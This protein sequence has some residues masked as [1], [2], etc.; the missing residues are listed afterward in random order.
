MDSD[1]PSPQLCDAG[2]CVAPA[3]T[4]VNFIA[5]V[6]GNQQQLTVDTPSESL[7]VLGTDSA[8]NAVP[9]ASVTFS[10][11]QNNGHLALDAVQVTDAQGHAENV[12]ILGT[13]AGSNEVTASLDAGPSVAFSAMGAAGP[14]ERLV[15]VSGNSQT[16][17]V[18]TALL[19][20]LVAAV[21]DI[22][23]NLTPLTIAV[24][25]TVTAGNGSLLSMD[26]ETN[27][28]GRAQ[29]ELK[30]GQTSGTNTVKVEA[31][32]LM[33][34]QFTATGTA[35]DAA[36]L[37]IEGGD[38]QTAPGN[39]QLPLPFQV[40]VADA[41]DNPKSG[42][43]VTFSASASDGSFSGASTQTTNADGVAQN[44]F[45]ITRLSGA[46][47]ATVSSSGLT[48]VDFSATAT[49]VN[50]VQNP[51]ITSGSSGWL[52]EGPMSWTDE[53]ES[54]NGMFKSEAMYYPSSWAY[55]CLSVTPGLPYSLSVDILQ[56]AGQAC[57]GLNQR[58]EV[59][60][61]WY[62]NGYP[63]CGGPMGYAQFI[64]LDGNNSWV[65]LT[66]SGSVPAD[67]YG[68]F[69]SLISRCYD[70]QTPTV[71]VVYFDNVYFSQ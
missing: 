9:N 63:D 28:E 55:Q 2:S 68:A 53:L 43:S 4:P 36:T 3:V 18:D 6:S 16:G 22:H 64:H 44:Y 47:T 13:I 25:F 5:I 27:V 17:T 70:D 33:E 11:T 54:G 51:G 19:L 49:A 14:P 50:F 29:A 71:N 21:A 40:R 37:A 31:S 46:K 34:S 12:L 8:G 41:F 62:T 10:I 48:P 24:T 56:A 30:L 38:G 42:V 26:A 35:G 20:P 45:T 65:E 32:G 15:R 59:Y 1:C 67:V 7:V 66:G 60:L 69:I 58:T 52:L 57:T 23:G 61:S 39:T